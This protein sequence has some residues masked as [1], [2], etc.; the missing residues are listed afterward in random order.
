MLE[1]SSFIFSLIQHFQVVPMDYQGPTRHHLA[2]IGTEVFKSQISLHVVQKRPKYEKIFF[3]L[4]S[5][6]YQ[7]SLE[8]A[9]YTVSHRFKVT[10]KYS[11][12][13]K[14]KREILFWE[15]YG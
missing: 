12:G 1:F 7:E 8:W 13:L 11:A 2:A 6:S 15:T 5:D 3:S 10:L 4:R 14:K 9:L